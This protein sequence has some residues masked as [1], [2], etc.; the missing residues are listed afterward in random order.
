MSNIF[1]LKLSG[2]LLSQGSHQDLSLESTLRDLPLYHFQV[3][4]GCLGITVTEIFEKNPLLPGVILMEDDKFMG[5][6]SRRRLLEYLIK[7]QGIELFLNLPLKVLYSYARAEMLILSENTTILTAAQQALRRS[8]E[9]QGEPIIVVQLEPKSYQLLDVHALNIAY[10]QI[11]GIETQVRYERAQAQMIQSEKMAS[12]GRLVDGVAH[13]ILD[14]VGFIWGNLTYITDYTDN[15]IE[16]LSTY[17]A[18][19]PNIP[20]E[21]S[22]LKEEIEFDFL[23]TDLPRTIA[24]IKA[25]AER[26]T[27]L[28]TSLQNFCHIDDVYPKPADLHTVINGIILLLKSRLTGE[29]EV[30]KNYGYLPPVSCYAGQLNQVFMNML[31]NAINVL[32]NEAVGQ[33]LAKEFRGTVLKDPAHKPRINITTEVCSPENLI[34][35]ERP[36]LRWVS[37]RIADNGPGMSLEKQEKILQSFSTEKRAEKETSLAVSYQIVT[38]KHGGRFRMRSQIGVGTEFEVLLPLI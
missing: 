38:A 37:I 10:W 24:S 1:D 18:I 26:L 23:Q 19:L 15:L 3:Q 9:L 30:V 28:A 6:I 2:P 16:L 21:I 5:M 4:L 33:D 20:A 12:L 27:K 22:Q 29:I 7:P 13:E 36:H 8:P 17:E 11:R 34:D 35:A 31:T 14:P 25:G 32:L